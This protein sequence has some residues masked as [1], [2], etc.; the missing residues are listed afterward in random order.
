MR[1]LPPREFASRIGVSVK[2]LQRWDNI[3]KLTA[4]R[5]P[6]NRRFYTEDQYNA[7]M[8]LS[9]TIDKKNIIYA[10]VSSNGQKDDLTNQVSFLQQYCNANG[11]IV[12]DVITDIG[13]GLNYNRKKME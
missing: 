13:S 11:I 3:D 9:N 2:T 5:T 1:D 7:Y 10:R 12:D 6:T 4:Y 8:G